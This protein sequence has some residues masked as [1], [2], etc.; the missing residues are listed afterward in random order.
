MEARAAITVGIDPLT[1]DWEGTPEIEVL[2]GILLARV[3]LASGEQVRTLARL[4][5]ALDL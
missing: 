4:L 2:R 5:D 1:L 3:H